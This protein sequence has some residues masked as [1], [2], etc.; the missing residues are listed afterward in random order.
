[1]CLTLRRSIQ[2]FIL[3]FTDWEL[4]HQQAKPQN[5]LKEVD[6]DWEKHQ[7]RQILKKITHQRKFQLY[8]GKMVSLLGMAPYETIMIQ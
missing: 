5:H 7:S 8:F 4:K 3:T 1:M 6:I 2:V